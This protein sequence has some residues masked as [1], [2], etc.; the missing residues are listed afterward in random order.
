MSQ[1]GEQLRYSVKISGTVHTG[2]YQQRMSEKMCY[3]QWKL[4]KLEMDLLSKHIYSCLPGAC[5]NSLHPHHYT[6]DSGC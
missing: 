3:H 2:L 1:A 4:A 6:A 5:V